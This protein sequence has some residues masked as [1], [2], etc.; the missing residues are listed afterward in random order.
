MI[1]FSLRNLYRS[2]R[3]T[4]YAR[5]GMVATTQP[6]ASQIGRDA[7]RGRNM[8]IELRHEALRP[9]PDYIRDPAYGVLYGSTEPRADSAIAV[10]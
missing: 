3:S 4:T 8:R 9:R 6:L 10:L 5:H 1:P 2:E 7:Q